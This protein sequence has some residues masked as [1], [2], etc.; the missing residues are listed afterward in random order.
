MTDDVD[1]DVNEGVAVA[2]DVL[3][4]ADWQM[5]D[6]CACAGTDDTTNVLLAMDGQYKRA[7]PPLACESSACRRDVAF[8]LSFSAVKKEPAF[9]L[10]K[11][12]AGNA[13]KPTHASV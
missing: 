12:P 3:T 1:D 10:V 9:Q 6:A 4:V 11:D 13:R 7:N 8:R 2:L 5:Y